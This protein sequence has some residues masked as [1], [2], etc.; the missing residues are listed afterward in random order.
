MEMKK[1]FNE[2]ELAI[3]NYAWENKKSVFIHKYKGL[4]NKRD[5]FAPNSLKQSAKYFKTKEQF[6]RDILEDYIFLQNMNY[7]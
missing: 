1:Y 5:I 4:S 6:M 2:K 7:V 3:I